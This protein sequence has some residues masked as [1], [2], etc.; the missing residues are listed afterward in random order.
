LE[1]RPKTR[2]KSKGGVKSTRRKK[3]K[4][5]TG[6]GI[7]ETKKSGEQGQKK[8]DRV[9][10]MRTKMKS[11]QGK[12]LGETIPQHWGKRIGGLGVISSKFGRRKGRRGKAGKEKEA[13]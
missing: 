1:K 5:A 6:F 4:Q 7:G 9:V 11:V 13:F 10:Q 3:K 12:V 2:K 8:Q